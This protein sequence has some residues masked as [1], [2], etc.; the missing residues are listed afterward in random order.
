MLHVFCGDLR[1]VSHE[2]SHDRN[3]L[4]RMVLLFFPTTSPLLQLI[5]RSLGEEMRKHKSKREEE[6]QTGRGA[7]KAEE[8]EKLEGRKWTRGELN[9]ETGD[10][11]R[12]KMKEI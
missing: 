6:I 12:E 7:Q 5:P 8:E 10:N 11:W 2:T 4:H 3:H 1:S 9:V